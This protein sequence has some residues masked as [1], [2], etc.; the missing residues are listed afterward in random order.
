MKKIILAS[1]ILFLASCQN[2]TKELSRDKIFF[3][4]TKDSVLGCFQFAGRHLSMIYFETNGKKFEG[5]PS[6]NHDLFLDIK[7]SGD[8]LY[9]SCPVNAIK[10]RYGICQNP[11]REDKFLTTIKEDGN[12]DEQTLIRNANKENFF[13][14][15]LPI[16]KVTVKSK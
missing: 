7:K 11:S 8:S 9:I 16:E 2:K 15:G 5:N 10:N 3:V 14:L 6:Y 12:L 13:K 4:E 1:A